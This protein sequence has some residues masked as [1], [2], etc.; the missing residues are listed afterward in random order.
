MLLDSTAGNP[1]L[2]FSDAAAN[3]LT[4]SVNSAD[5]ADLKESYKIIELADPDSTLDL[6]KVSI[7]L[8]GAAY[9]LGTTFADCYS[10]NQVDNDLVLT[11]T[12]PPVVI[13]S[14]GNTEIGGYQKMSEALQAIKNV[15]TLIF[16]NFSNHNHVE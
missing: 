11:Y 15:D 7:T 5:Y 14:L 16:V 2:N 12:P 10:I 13:V 8:D 3:A 9:P 6:S 4:I 1:K